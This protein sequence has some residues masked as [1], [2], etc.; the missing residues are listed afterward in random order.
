MKVLGLP[1]SPLCRPSINEARRCRGSLVPH[2]NGCEMQR[3]EEGG[4]SAVLCFVRS[5]RGAVVS[6][7]VCAAHR[8]HCLDGNRREHV[9]RRPLHDPD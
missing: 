7:S 3:V 4:A 6:G 1:S 5:L 9:P 8:D 2:P